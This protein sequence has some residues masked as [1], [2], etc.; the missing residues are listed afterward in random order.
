MVTRVARCDERGAALFVVMLVV[1]MLSG[2]GL[3]AARSATL[4]ITASG[5]E[6]QM[7]Q[8]HYITEYSIL[9]ITSELSTNRKDAYVR[10]MAEKPDSKCKASQGVTG[11]TCYR[12]GYSDIEGQLSAQDAKAKLVVA[13]DQKTQTPGGLGLGSLE[14]NFLVEMSDLAPA[15]PPVYGN[16]LTSA[17]AVNLTYMAVTL[18]ATGQIHSSIVNK[19][20]VDNAIAGTASVETARAHLIVGPL[21]RP[22]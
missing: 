3:F 10:T 19:S 22:M 2:V 15:N 7:T 20:T 4:S 16:D 9:A 17:G 12:F 1:M 13:S 8:T 14:P 18:T 11:A 5:Y 21:R 6:R